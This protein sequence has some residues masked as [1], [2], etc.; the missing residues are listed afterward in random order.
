MF[1]EAATDGGTVNLEEYT[2]SVTGYISKCI[3]VTVSKTITTHPN[4]KQWMTAE[5]RM[6]LKTCDSEQVTGSQENKSQTVICPDR[7]L[8]Y[9]SCTVV[10]TCF[11]TTTIPK[12]KRPTVSFLNNYRP[13]TLTSIMKCFES[14]IMTHQGPACPF[15]G[16]PAVHVPPQPL[17]R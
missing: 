17:Y 1:K 2:A 11:K 9:L 13:I 12:P 15:S 16:P 8:Q 5:V 14:L 3:D 7:H 10:P 4:Q 6:L